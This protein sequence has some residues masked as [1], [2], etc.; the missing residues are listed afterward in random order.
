MFHLCISIFYYYLPLSVFPLALADTE[1]SN[2]SLANCS[3]LHIWNVYV[4]FMCT[5]QAGGNQENLTHSHCLNKVRTISMHCSIMYEQKLAMVCVWT[6]KT[7]KSIEGVC[8][9]QERASKQEDK[10]KCGLDAKFPFLV[11]IKLRE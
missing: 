4:V 3:V 8:W 6:L 1:I 7:T 5:H 2:S 10:T 11:R 9:E